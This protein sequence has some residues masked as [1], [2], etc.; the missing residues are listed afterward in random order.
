M[1]MCSAILLLLGKGQLSE[2][3]NIGH[4]NEYSVLQIARMLV[5]IIGNDPNDNFQNYIEFVEDRYYND[6]T[7]RI[8]STKL[9]Q[10]GWEPKIGMKEGLESV[11]AWYQNNKHIYN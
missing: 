2:I 4:D 8:D 11:V 7:Y 10:L 6:F 5:G 3:Y 1:D 9:R